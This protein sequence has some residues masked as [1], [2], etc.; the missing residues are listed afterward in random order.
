MTVP[1]AA[2]AYVKEV[3]LSD[4][5]DSVVLGQSPLW[6]QGVIDIQLLDSPIP[7]TPTTTT[8]TTTTTSQKASSGNIS[9]T[10]LGS[11]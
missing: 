6:D 3:N 2:P 7:T 10:K 9:G 1:K 5:S 11:I 4:G 8:P